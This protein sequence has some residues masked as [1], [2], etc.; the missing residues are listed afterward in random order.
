MFTGIIEGT[1]RVAGV[2]R[3]P[4]G[5]ARR[6]AARL[7]VD[8]GRQAAG[9]RKGQSVAINGVCL[10]VAGISPAGGRCHFEMIE[11]TV[12]RTALG[13]L[14]RGDRVNVERSL[15]ASGRLEGHFVLG[16]VDGVGAVRSIEERPGEVRVWIG[17]PAALR[18]LMVEKGSVAVDGVS[19]TVAGLSRGAFMVCLIPH[20][21]RATS[22]AGL[23]EGDAVNI[24]TDILGKYAAR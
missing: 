14:G 9:L 18:R 22:F 20:T 11:E 17:A 10:T 2:R 16:H 4:P 7:A 1:G 13:S 6:A 23:R 21:V 24:E 3:I 5:G 15:R 8:L 12:D 19:L